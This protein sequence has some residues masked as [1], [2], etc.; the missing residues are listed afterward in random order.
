VDRLDGRG[1]PGPPEPRPV[2][3]VEQLDMLEARHLGGPARERL[4]GVQGRPAGAVADRVDLGRDPAGGRLRCVR[5][6]LLRL[7]EPDPAPGRRRACPPP[8]SIGSRS[9]AVREA[10]VPSAKSFSQPNRARPPGGPSGSPLWSP[11]SIAAPSCS[12]RID[13]WTRIGSSSRSSSAR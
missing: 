5:G 9:A 6:H 8:R 12:E 1:D 11:S 10:S 7:R 2:I 4:Q 13:A 3:R